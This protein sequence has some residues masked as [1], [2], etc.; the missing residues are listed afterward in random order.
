MNGW[1]KNG[2]MD[3]RGMNGGGMNDWKMD[4]WMEE[5]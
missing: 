3:A 5:E 2:L 4:G 1:F